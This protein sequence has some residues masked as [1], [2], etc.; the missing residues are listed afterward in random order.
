MAPSSPV[1]D[2]PPP[3][4][5]HPAFEAPVAPVFQPAILLGILSVP[6]PVQVEALV[7]VRRSVAVG[8]QYSMLPTLSLPGNAARLELDA[9]QLT[10]RWFPFHGAFY[11]GSGFGYQRLRASIGQ[12]IDGGDLRVLADMSTLFLSP[13]LGWL[14]L[15]RS[16]FAIG[17]NLGVQVPLPRDPNVSVTYNGQPLPTQGGPAGVATS[18]SDDKNKVGDVARIIMRYPIPNIDLLKIGFAF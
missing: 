14:W 17:I 10:F 1:P 4:P 11:L 9:T 2:T 12:T 5:E 8:V 3:P 6:R 18:A 7:R 13:Q 15:T 16:G